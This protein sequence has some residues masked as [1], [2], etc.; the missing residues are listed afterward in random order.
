M[1]QKNE[2]GVNTCDLFLQ[3]FVGSIGDD[4]IVVE[5]PRGRGMS[6]MK[7]RSRDSSGQ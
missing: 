5:I 7:R 6:E 1:T 2:V 4:V 3:C